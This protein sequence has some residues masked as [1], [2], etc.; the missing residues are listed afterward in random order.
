MPF[1]PGLRAPGGSGKGLG[2]KLCPGIKCQRPRWRLK[3]AREDRRGPASRGLCAHISGSRRLPQPPGGSLHF[4]PVHAGALHRG[5]QAPQ[6]KGARRGRLS[7]SPFPRKV[8][9]LSADF[10][11]GTDWGHVDLINQRCL[12]PD[13]ARNSWIGSFPGMAKR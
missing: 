7:G 10:V 1:D 9:D 6:G 2:W 12:P 11:L 3:T 13:G 4:R 5:R 8:P